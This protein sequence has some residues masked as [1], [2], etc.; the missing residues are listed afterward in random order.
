[1][2]IQWA[3]NRGTGAVGAANIDEV[4]NVGALEEDDAEQKAYF[5]NAGTGVDIYAAGQA[6]QS[7]IHVGGYNSFSYISDP[8]NSQYEQSKYQGTSMASPQVCGILACLLENFPGMS[9]SE[10]KEWIISNSVTGAMNNS[11]S[12]DSM[13]VTSLWGGPNR[14]LRWQNQRPTQGQ[15][16]PR[17][18]YKNRPLTGAVYPRTAVRRRG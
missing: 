6:I 15:S 16:L 12:D 1:L 11:G 4:I 5:S 2:N 8:R 14:L 3:L 17:F 13:S 7:S 10:A 18:N 9:P